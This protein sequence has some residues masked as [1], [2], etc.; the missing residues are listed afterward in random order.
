[1]IKEKQIKPLINKHLEGTDKFL[2][3][4]LIK[5]GNQILVF[6]DGDKDVKMQDCIDLSRYIESQLDRE[7]EDYSLNVSS[8]GLDQPLKLFRQ[9]T[10]NVGRVLSITMGDGKKKKGTLL[11]AEKQGLTVMPEQDKKKKKTDKEITEEFIR[12]DQLKE[13]KVVVSFKKNN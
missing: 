3:E 6:I 8:H 11:K 2:V 9:Y 10:K 13:V 12:F 1:M 4:L 7:T 5:A